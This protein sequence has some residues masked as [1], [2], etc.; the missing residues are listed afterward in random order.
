MHG[1]HCPAPSSASQVATRTVSATGHAFSE[2]SAT[3]PAPSVAPCAREVFVRQRHA[4]RAAIP[5]S[6]CR[7]SRRR[8]PRAARPLAP[9]AASTTEAS[10]AP[11][12]ISYTPGWPT[13]PDSV[14][15]AEPGCVGVPSSR[16]QDA[17]WRAISATWANVSALLIERRA[18]PDALLEGHRRRELGDRRTAVEMVHQ[19]RLLPGHVAAGDDAELQLRRPRRPRR[20]FLDRLRHAVD[21]RGR[22]LAHAHDRLVR[23]DR[24]GGELRAVEHQVRRHLA[25]RAV[26]EARRLALGRVDDDDRATPRRRDGAQLASRWESR[27]R[28]GRAG[29][30]ARRR[31]IS[32][33][34]RRRARA[35][36]R[37]L[38][39]RS[40]GARRAS[41][42][43]AET[44]AS[45][46]GS[47]DSRRGA[48]AGARRRAWRSSRSSLLLPRR[49]GRRW[50]SS[51]LGVPERRAHSE[52]SGPDRQPQQQK[53]RER[54]RAA[55]RRAAAA[56][57]LRPA[58]DRRTSTASSTTPAQAM[59]SAS[60][61]VARRIAAGAEAVQ[62]RD[63][64]AR[65]GEPVDRA[66]ASHSRSAGAAC[67]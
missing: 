54:A 22:G 64:P 42:A 51:A 40:P 59:L 14:S 16:N 12:S 25:Q 67:S 23:A 58:G 11:C 20:A 35:L 36:V 29:R 50:P 56:E 43:L 63:R 21:A 66:P 3:T 46:R 5:R 17:P 15:S 48:S 32:G 7:R 52:P 2:S 39:V 37:Q 13:G 27:R 61:H 33:A 9:P 55:E 6:T 44:P 45:R 10:E 26:L 19:R 53:Q 30:P 24:L 28:R 4:R 62:Q 34:S 8:A 18:A 38:S 57:V 47:P 41:L 49:R 60:S 65:V 31:S 1:P